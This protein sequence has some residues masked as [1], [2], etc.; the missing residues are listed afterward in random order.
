[1]RLNLDEDFLIKLGR[2]PETLIST[3]VSGITP[4]FITPT[5]LQWQVILRVDDY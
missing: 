2:K 4:Y 5:I 3:A 1:L